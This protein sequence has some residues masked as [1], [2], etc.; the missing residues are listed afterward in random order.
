MMLL[1]DRKVLRSSSFAVAGML[2]AK[3]RFQSNTRDFMKKKF[4]RCS[5]CF[6]YCTAVSS[7]SSFQFVVL[8]VLESPAFVS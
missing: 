6:N 5:L 4:S 3:S 1:G 2:F 7:P 8:I